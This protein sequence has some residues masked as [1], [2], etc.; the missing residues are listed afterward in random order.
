VVTGFAVGAA[1]LGGGAG[2]RNQ[3]APSQTISPAKSKGERKAPGPQSAA[4]AKV[5]PELVQELNHAATL[6]DRLLSAL[7]DPNVAD[8]DRLDQWS[9]LTLQA[10][11]RLSNARADRLAAAEA[12]RDRVKKL[13]L[14]IANLA[15]TDENQGFLKLTSIRL[16][17]AEHILASE[18]EDKKIGF[19]PGSLDTP[20]APETPAPDSPNG[21]SPPSAGRSNE[22]VPDPRNPVSQEPKAEPPVAAGMMGRMGMVGMMAG[23]MGG[24]LDRPQIAAL[25][26]DL[27]SRES[28]PKSKAVLKKLDEPISMSFANPT[29]FD[30]VLK[31]IKQAT[32][33]ETY[34]GI[35]IY[36]DPKG[37]KEASATLQTQVSLDLDG[38]PLKTT[39]RLI[40]K[41][42]GLAY[43][44][45]DGVLI[46]SSVQGVKEELSEAQSELDAVQPKQGGFGGMS[47]MGGGMR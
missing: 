35:P 22:S 42:N 23:M 40:L 21:N 3:D 1:Q 19:G 39:L 8:I 25:A 30:D 31:Y 43:C 6:F 13:H 17:E 14:R 47:G 26:A 18:N 15:G 29:P 33:T 9:A 20:K 2:G 41:Q 46:I 38:V 4:P 5:S 10:Q 34:S 37:L 44:V 7:R 12:H 11:Q 45:R 16:N 27:A 32:T 24:G 28:D 36:V